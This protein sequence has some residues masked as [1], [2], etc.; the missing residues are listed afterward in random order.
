VTGKVKV[1]PGPRPDFFV[2]KVPRKLVGVKKKVTKLE[3][4]S[5]FAFASPRSASQPPTN[6]EAEGDRMPVL[7]DAV[8]C[9]TAKL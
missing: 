1:T 7:V 9:R 3:S 6:S 5:V 8:C 2:I 4:F